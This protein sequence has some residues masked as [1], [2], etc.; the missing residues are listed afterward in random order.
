MLCFLGDRLLLILFFSSESS[1]KGSFVMAL[2]VSEVGSD[3]YQV[4]T[5][6]GMT[7]FLHNLSRSGFFAFEMGIFFLYAYISGMSSILTGFPRPRRLSRLNS[8]LY[9]YL[10]LW[11]LCAGLERFD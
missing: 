6:F 4:C 8:S 7:S 2:A 5:Y 10:G 1:A 11:I 3:S 9:P